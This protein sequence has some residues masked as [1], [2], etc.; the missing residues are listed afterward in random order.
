MCRRGGPRCAGH[1]RAQVVSAEAHVFEVEQRIA[2]GK[3]PAY[4]AETRRA[5]AARRLARAQY[6]YGKTKQGINDRVARLNADPNRDDPSRDIERQAIFDDTLTYQLQ[7]AKHRK[8]VCQMGTEQGQS[9]AQIVNSIYRNGGFTHDFNRGMT[10]TV[11]FMVSLPGHERKIRMDGKSKSDLADQ[12]IRYAREKRILLMHEG[13]YVGGW[14][15]PDNRILYLDV[16][17]VETN[18]K[19]ARQ[20]AIDAKQEAFWDA[21]CRDEVFV[22]RGISEQRDN[23]QE[24]PL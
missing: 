9:P 10:P 8:K 7:L 2:A 24:E 15:N 13:N 23:Y 17:R 19:R 5:A 18:V 12:L 11:G 4:L 6:N 14:V 21:Q 22:L 1:M 20:S 3:I 16:S